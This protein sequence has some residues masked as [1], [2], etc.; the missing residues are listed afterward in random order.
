MRWRRPPVEPAEQFA[1]AVREACTKLGL[2][3]VAYAPDRVDLQGRVNGTVA[4]EDVRAACELEPVELWARIVL[5]ALS[6][7]ATALEAG[8]D[9]ADLAAVRPL[10]RS[11][12]VTEGAVLAEDVVRRP[13]CDGLVEVLVADLAGAL[14]TVPPGVLAGWGVEA[15][16]LLDLGRRQVLDSGLLSR[17]EVDLGGVAAV[18]LESE[19]A[20][21]ATYVHGIGAYV[22][23]PPAGLLVALP[24]RH[25]LLCAPIGERQQ[26]LDAAQALLLNAPEL[27]RAGP[28][29][30]SPDLWW[31]RGG[32]LTRLPGSATSL[33][34]PVAFLEVLDALPG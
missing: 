29:G 26:A 1:R 16:P 14:R 3:V 31:W 23:V 34:P 9:L 8:V 27:E 5:D 33:S 22:D 13:L 11:R 17:R 21:A 4:L 25:L 24:T 10:L 30:L 6:G 2:T 19:S 7:L 20:F 32:G 18:A 28:G 15:G 12:V